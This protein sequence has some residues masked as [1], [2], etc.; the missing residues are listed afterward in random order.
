MQNLFLL[1]SFTVDCQVFK[2]GKRAVTMK[3]SNSFISVS[4]LYFFCVYLY[5]KKEYIAMLERVM[6]ICASEWYA[7]ITAWINI[8]GKVQLKFILTST[9]WQFSYFQNVVF[10]FKPIFSFWWM[11]KI[12]SKRCLENK[13]TVKKTIKISIEQK[14]DIESLSLL[15]EKD[16]KNRLKSKSKPIP[17][18]IQLFL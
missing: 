9:I 6:L 2:L 17:L 7:E 5:R 13:V 8:P 11:S 4:S 14:T 10:S 1:L 16:D 15:W 12:W 3:N 18:N